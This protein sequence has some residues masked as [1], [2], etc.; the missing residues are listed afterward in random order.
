MPEWLTSL[1]VGEIVIFL[2][3]VTIF[4][5]FVMKIWK[6]VRQ[7]FKGIE[8]FLTAWNGTPEVRDDSDTIIKLKVP[9][10]IAQIEVLRD[11]LQNSHQDAVIP[12]LRDD[13]DTKASKEDVE[14]VAKA[15]A[16]VVDKLD[17]HITIAKESDRSQ[18]E[19]AR[20]VE[21]L[22]TRWAEN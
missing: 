14:A 9:G 3:G 12:N 4:G 6:P 1:T 15:L 22:A 10:V 2:S 16:V 20:Q 5:G 8:S 19:M 17:E 18:A 11:Q 13:L 7:V 21:S